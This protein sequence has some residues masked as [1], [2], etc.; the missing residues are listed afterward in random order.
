MKIPATVEAIRYNEYFQA[1][2]YCIVGAFLFIARSTTETDTN[3][4]EKTI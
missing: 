1:I 3:K 4:A 2:S